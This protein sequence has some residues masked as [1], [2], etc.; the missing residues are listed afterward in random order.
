MLEKVTKSQRQSQSSQKNII[1]L[2]PLKRGASWRCLSLKSLNRDC[3]CNYD[4]NN[5]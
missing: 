5:L 4:N 3:E 2:G 1:Y